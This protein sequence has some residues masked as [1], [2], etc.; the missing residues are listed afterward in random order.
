[1]W[2]L[3]SLPFLLF[4]CMAVMLRQRGATASWRDALVMAGVNSAVWATAGAELLSLFKAISFWPLLLWWGVPTAVLIW[5]W[6][7]GPGPPLPT[8]PRDPIV[9]G[10]TVVIALLLSLTLLSGLL[11]IPSNWDALSYHLPRQVYWM[12]QQHVGFFSTNDTRMLTMPP[13]AEYLGLHLMIMSGGDY[14][15][16]CV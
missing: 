6:R 5:L 3:G 7:R 10:V 9:A 13:L 15:A 14:W 8:W 11:T 4:L 1:M 12:Q 2:A 16:N